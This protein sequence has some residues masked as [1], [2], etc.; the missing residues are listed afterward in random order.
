M[1][2]LSGTAGVLVRR[3]RGFSKSRRCRGGAGRRLRGTLA[4]V[5]PLFQMI[6]VESGQDGL[7]IFLG[8]GKDR[9]L[10][11]LLPGCA[12]KQN[13]TSVSSQDS[14]VVLEAQRLGR[15]G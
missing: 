6:F 4:Q 5:A 12:V 2:I 7:P 10:M 11:V 3:S 8:C 1:L 14:E 9:E 15:A 13:D